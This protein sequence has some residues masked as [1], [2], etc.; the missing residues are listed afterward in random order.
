MDAASRGRVPGR[1]GDPAA[2]AA[3][4]AGPGTGAPVAA[5]LVGDVTGTWVSAG[6]GVSARRR[7]AAGQPR[8]GAPPGAAQLSAAYPG[9]ADALGAVPVGAAPPDLP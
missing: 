1:A 6:T 2:R 8:F 9:D 5:E 4:W 7:L 3:G